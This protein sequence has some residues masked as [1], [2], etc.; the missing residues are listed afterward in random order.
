MNE[1]DLDEKVELLLMQHLGK[2]YL[3]NSNKY[4]LKKELTLLFLKHGEQEKE[5]DMMQNKKIINEYN[6]A[7]KTEMHQFPT[8]AKRSQK[9]PRYDLIPKCALDRLA[10]RFTGDIINNIPSGGALKYGEGN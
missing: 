1:R 3:Q 8:G 5:V 2:L 4:Q 7:F 9:M 10:Q 6:Q